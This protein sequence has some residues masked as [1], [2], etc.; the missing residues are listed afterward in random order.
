MEDVVP[1][2]SVKSTR[3]ICIQVIQESEPTVDDDF[4]AVLDF[5][6]TSKT[7]VCARDY[8]M[9]CSWKEE[10]GILQGIQTRRRT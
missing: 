7:G 9:W 8:I 3:K 2:S 6:I 10:N 5:M 4:V 1:S